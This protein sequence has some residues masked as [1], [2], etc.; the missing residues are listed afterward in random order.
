M[1]QSKHQF[2]NF[3][4]EARDKTSISTDSP[5]NLLQDPDFNSL[6]WSNLQVA[7]HLRCVQKRESEGALRRWLRKLKP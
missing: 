2:D 1:E 7:Q 4:I 5:A 3:I 6:F